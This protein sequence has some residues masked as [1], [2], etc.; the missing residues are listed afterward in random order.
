MQHNIIYMA[1]N[2]DLKKLADSD[3]LYLQGYLKVYSDGQ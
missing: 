1:N 3:P 2:A